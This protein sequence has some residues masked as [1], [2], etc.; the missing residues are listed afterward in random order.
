MP[1]MAL[2]SFLRIQIE[3]TFSQVR[4]QFGNENNLL[5]PAPENLEPVTCRIEWPWK[6]QVGL[7]WHGLLPPRGRLLEVD[8]LV[9]PPVIST[10]VSDIM[11]STYVFITKGT[12]I[13]SLCQ[14]RIPLSVPDIVTQLQISG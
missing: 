5:L 2:A 12:Q 8:G 7:K 10:W 6:V 14:I 11:V 4:P 3:G 9:P 13:M 1:Q